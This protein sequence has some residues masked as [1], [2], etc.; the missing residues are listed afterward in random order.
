MNYYMLA[1]TNKETNTKCTRLAVVYYCNSGGLASCL[2]AAS[3][4][5]VVVVVVQPSMKLA[6][7]KY[8]WNKT[9]STA[10]STLE[11]R[12]CQYYYI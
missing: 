1:I 7:Y 10:A 4:V 6:H 11:D 2:V 12:L 9:T 8:E 5:L 3:T